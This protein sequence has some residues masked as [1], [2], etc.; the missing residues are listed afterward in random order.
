MK[1]QR[2]AFVVR[3]VS[4]VDNF[5][6]LCREFEISRPTGYKWVGRYGQT[7]S[8]A[9][10]EEISRRPRQSP[11]RVKEELEKRVIQ[12]RQETGWGAKKLQKVLERDEGIR[13]G[14]S[15]VNRILRR[16]GLLREED[17]HRPANHRFEY[18]APNELWQMD[19]KGQFAM[20]RGYCY[21]LSVLDDHSRYLVGL[22]ALSSPSLEGVEGNLIAIFE[23]YGL[24]EAMLMDHGT[25]WWSANNGHGLTRLSVMLIRQ[26]IQL[27]YSGVGHPQTQGKVEKWHDTLRRA[28]RH[29]GQLPDNLQGWSNLFEPIRHRYNHVRPHE[30]IDMQCPA[31]R[32][33]ASRR[34]YQPQPREWEYPIGATVKRVDRDGRLYLSG[35]HYFVSEALVGQPVRVE[36]IGDTFLISY[37]HMYVREIVAGQSRSVVR[38][39]S[40]SPTS[41]SRDFST[42]SACATPKTRRKSA[43]GSAPAEAAEKSPGN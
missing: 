21:P 8:F 38:P 31:D 32:Y 2:I 35:C 42:A 28:V 41:L 26:G 14:R 24:P 11:G 37:R 5:S 6:Q 23:Q 29:H 17:R 43:L 3:A 40:Q 13:I 15:T 7:K 12:L 39:I 19:F 22:A 30:G 20:G 16:N 34:P 18:A 36:T 1:E 10:L 33:S 27:K 4:G 9:K 25:P